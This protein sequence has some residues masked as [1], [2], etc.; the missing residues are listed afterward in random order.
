MAEGTK[1]QPGRASVPHLM[2][3]LVPRAVLRDRALGR[4]WPID[5]PV[6]L[7][8]TLRVLPP[9]VPAEVDINDPFRSWSDSWRWPCSAVSLR[10][11]PTWE[12]RCCQLRHS[13]P[14]RPAGGREGSPEC[15]AQGPTACCTPPSWGPRLLGPEDSRDHEVP[16]CRPQAGTGVTA[17]SSEAPLPPSRGSVCSPHGPLCRTWRRGPHEA[18]TQLSAPW[19]WCLVA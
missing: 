10:C 16:T 7:P 14:V 6:H 4:P 12:C 11:P 15:A 13:C 8:S 9:G 19:P 3:C 17:L 5:I 1:R 2:P 18:V